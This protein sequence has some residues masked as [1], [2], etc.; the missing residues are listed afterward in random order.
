[1]NALALGWD[2]HRKFSKASLQEM[3]AEGQIH[4]VERARLEHR[5]RQAMRQWLARVPSGTPVALEAVFG[6]PWIADL[7]E[8]VG[9]EPHLGHP[10]AIKVLAQHEAK[11]DRCDADRLAKF[12]LRGILP[13]SYLAPP[14]VRQRRER[15]R[16][17]IALVRLHTGVKKRKRGGNRSASSSADR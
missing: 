15:M 7:L 16:Y 5:D 3:T 1:M 2:V 17:R 8:E 4:V 11:G 14:E 6:W 10:P 12:Q 9:L 13:E